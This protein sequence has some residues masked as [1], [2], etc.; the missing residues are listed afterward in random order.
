[1]GEDEKQ[2]YFFDAIFKLNLWFW[3]F[4]KTAE[5]I[6]KRSPLSLAMLHSVVWV[7]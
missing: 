5:I 1:M 3:P 7:V 2:E 6:M 4:L